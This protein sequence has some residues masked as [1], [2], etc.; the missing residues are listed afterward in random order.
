M[1]TLA[2]IFYL[3]SFVLLIFS[4]LFVFRKQKIWWFLSVLIAQALLVASIQLFASYTLYGQDVYVEYNVITNTLRDG[5]INFQNAFGAALYDSVLIPVV[6]IVS[7]IKPLIFYKA[8][9]TFF[10][11]LHV[12]MVYLILERLRENDIKLKLSLTYAIFLFLSSMMFGSMRFGIGLVS[13]LALLLLIIRVTA[14]RRASYLGFLTIILMASSITACYYTLGLN[15]LALLLL[16]CF[17]L[18]FFRNMNDALKK[19]FLLSIAIAL[20]SSFLY[21]FYLSLVLRQ[22]ILSTIYVL[23]RYSLITEERIEYVIGRQGFSYYIKTLVKI[24]PYVVSLLGIIL[25]LFMLALKKKIRSE[26]TLTKNNG[27]ILIWLILGLVLTTATTFIRTGFAYVIS[28][29]S[30]LFTLGVYNIYSYFTLLPTAKMRKLLTSVLIAVLLV[31]QFLGS[32][33]L[34]DTLLK[35]D[36]SSPVLDET[37]MYR[38]ISSTEF[39]DYHMLKYLLINIPRDKL[40]DLYSDTKISNSIISVASDLYSEALPYEPTSININPYALSTFLKNKNINGILILSSYNI[41]TGEAIVPQGTINIHLNDILGD[42][43]LVYN[44]FSLILL[45]E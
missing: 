40:T 5:K 11:M 24:F 34:V 41:L 3:I 33:Y 2:L 26:V 10:F 37:S 35:L 42:Y 31:T 22:H 1:F 25:E 45:R 15:S 43:N 6:C 29:F 4:F 13:Y 27:M 28:V 9:Y 16:L 23:L 14:M 7:G 44:S 17:M 12:L 18:I 30:P 21:T 20:I 39:S 32:T 19:A 8:T 38:G 36:T